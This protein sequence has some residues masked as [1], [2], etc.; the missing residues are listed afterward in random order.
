MFDTYRFAADN[1]L[2]DFGYEEEHLDVQSEVGEYGTEDEDEGDWTPHHAGTP[3]P[4]AAHRGH[5]APGG[6][7][8]PQKKPVKMATKAPAKKKPAAKKPAKK[9]AVKKA[10]PKRAKKAPKKAKKPVKKYKPAKKY[11]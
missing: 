1:D 6:E 2:D 11:K 9:A 10:A 4:P 8:P 7:A 3:A 5:P